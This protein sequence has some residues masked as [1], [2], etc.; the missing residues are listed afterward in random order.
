M[1]QAVASLHASSTTGRGSAESAYRQRRTRQ[2]REGLG[3]GVI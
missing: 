1:A 3:G 2:N